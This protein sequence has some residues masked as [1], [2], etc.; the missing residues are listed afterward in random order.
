MQIKRWIIKQAEEQRIKQL[1]QK[2]G[3]QPIVANVLAA[4]E[5]SDQQIESF[6]GNVPLE[7]PFCLADMDRAVERIRVAI[8]QQQKVA[9]YGDYDCDGVCAAAMLS[10]YLT[11]AGAN[12]VT[13]IPEREEGYGLSQLG[14]DRLLEQQVDLI[15]T[16]DNGIA[17]IEQADYAAERQVDLIITDHHQ[18]GQRLP[19]AS[20]VVDPHRPD[21]SSAFKHLSGAGVAFKLIAAMEDGDYDT[22]FEFAGD[23]VAIATIGDMMP[24][25]NENRTI[26]ARGLNM[27]RLTDR[28]GLH[29]LK[30][31]AGIGEAPSAE[32]IAFGLCPRIN[33]AGRFDRAKDAFALLASDNP[34]EAEYLAAELCSLNSERKQLEQ[35]ILEE[36]QQSIFKDPYLVHQHVIVA[37]GENWPQG[38]IG[39]VAGKICQMYQRP[40]VILSIHEDQAVGSARSLEGFSVY[41]A[42]QSCSDLLIQWGGHQQAGGM[43]IAAQDIDAFRRALLLYAQD[44]KPQRPVVNVDAALK[45]NEI[46]L[47]SAK[48]LQ[49]L[50]PFGHGNPT[51]L[52]AI[53]NAQL[54]KITPL[55]NG[56]HLRLTFSLQDQSFSALYF[57]M[58]LD[59]FYYKPSG[60][61]HLLVDLSVNVFHEQE[62]LSVKIL[63]MRP[64]QL[65]QTSLLNAADQFGMLM[66][67]EPLPDCIRTLMRPS[68]A[69]FAA[70]YQLLVRLKTFHGDA[71]QLYALT[72]KNGMNYAKMRVI[73]QVLQEHNLIAVGPDF[74]QAM[75]NPPR[76]NLDQS[77]L[78]QSLDNPAK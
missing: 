36:I 55:S 21:C 43:T 26:V 54:E 38:V 77:V 15:I 33:A 10:S 37:A 69:E 61:F 65:K 32:S 40:T 62:Q 19:K 29:A 49:Q 58:P 30:N 53:L 25:V 64:A 73:L 57:H 13:Y 63:D 31:K 48:Q 70:V 45:P 9:V 56:N 67:S 72:F 39:I 78:L 51:P 4:R 1:Q 2:Y 76:V 20:A 7:S 34:T 35:N 23:L 68:R 66:R 22:V 44:H 12:V 52:F 47:D 74:I 3:L 71:A 59:H 17:A 5:L 24:L 18:V 16:V 42:L 14:I 41:D 11:S 46:S 8:D 6:F 27:L 75:I 28:P 60:V 50:G